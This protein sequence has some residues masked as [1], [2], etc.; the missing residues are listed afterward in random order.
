MKVHFS[1]FLKFKQREDFS[2]PMQLQS[3]NDT[4]AQY[5]I[6]EEGLIQIL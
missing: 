6:F 5:Q 1:I 3:S 4:S 2:I